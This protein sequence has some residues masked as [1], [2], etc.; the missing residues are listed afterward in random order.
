MYH[1]SVCVEHDGKR[2]GMVLSAKSE[3][4]AVKWAESLDNRIGYCGNSNFQEAVARAG[5]MERDE[6]GAWGPVSMW[7]TA[8]RFEE[9]SCSSCGRSF[10]PGDHGYSHCKNHAGRLAK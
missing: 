1:L 3:S 7:R 2:S 4:D 5:M 10:G 6:R 9:T 8:F